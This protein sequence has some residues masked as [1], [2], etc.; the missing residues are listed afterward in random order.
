VEWTGGTSGVAS[1]DY[2]ND[3]YPDLY[4]GNTSAPGCKMFQ[5]QGNGTF[6]D[7]TSGAGL[8]GHDDTRTVNFLDYNNDG[9]LDIFVSNHDF[10]V[11]SSQLYRNNRNGT[12]TDVGAAMGLSGE[13]M[14]DYFGT[15]WADFNRDGAIDMFAA[16]HIDKYVLFRNDSCP[17][18][19]L[20][21]RLI[22]TVSNYHGIGAE[23]KTWVSAQCLTRFVVAGEGKHDFH[24]YDVEIG[25]DSSSS[26]DSLYV[27]WP[28][29]YVSR[30][31]SMIAANQFI[32]I[33]EGETGTA[34]E[35]QCKRPA[36]NDH[37]SNYPNPFITYTTLPGY[38][39]HRMEVYDIEGSRVGSYS[40]SRIG[41]DLGPGVYF[42]RTAS[43]RQII[44]IV[45]IR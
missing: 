39:A 8:I 17:G 40:G 32:T 7:V 41:A 37:L 22:G 38:E 13:W 16:G 28:S 20:I 14:G 3:G 43:T 29:G 9:F 10:Y 26:V 34:E 21:V 4:L 2:D 5:N 18:N 11:Y 42:V 45:K 27:Y 6:L 12:F 15:G 33:V 24:S 35:Y 44:R 30:L 19:Y 1:G 36:R 23:V 31:D 25:L